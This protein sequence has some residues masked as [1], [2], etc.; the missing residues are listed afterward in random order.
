MGKS[1]ISIKYFY[2]WLNILK[3]IEITVF[4]LIYFSKFNNLSSFIVYDLI[5]FKRHFI[6]PSHLYTQSVCHFWLLAIKEIYVRNLCKENCPSYK[7]NAYSR[8]IFHLFQLKS[9]SMC[10]LCSCCVHILIVISALSFYVL[11]IAHLI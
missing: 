3:Y 10:V 11:S 9:D 7:I 6:F 1:W 2:K 4:H 8:L 5:Y